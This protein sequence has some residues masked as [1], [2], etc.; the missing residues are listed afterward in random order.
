MQAKKMDLALK[1]YCRNSR[2]YLSLNLIHK[3]QSYDIDHV[4][5][6]NCRVLL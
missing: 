2:I 1:S 3:L 6:L 4:V 5:S